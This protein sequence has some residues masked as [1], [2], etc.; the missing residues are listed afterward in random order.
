MTWNTNLHKN[1]VFILGI[2]WET[3]VP[4]TKSLVLLYSLLLV[5]ALKMSIFIFTALLFQV[6]GSSLNFPPPLQTFPRVQRAQSCSVTAHQMTG[7]QE[8]KTVMRGKGPD[9]GLTPRADTLTLTSLATQ[10]RGLEMSAR[11]ERTQGSCLCNYLSPSLHQEAWGPGRRFGPTP[12]LHWGFKFGICRSEG[13]GTE[14]ENSP[15]LHWKIKFSKQPW[16]QGKNPVR[17]AE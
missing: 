7:D 12:R 17:E 9:S 16:T 10:A 6:L 3:S 11:D 4:W 8:P 15:D 13:P 5:T 2:S 14:A 1:I